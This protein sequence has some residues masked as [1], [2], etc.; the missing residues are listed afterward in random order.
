M[1]IARG[2][3]YTVT[4]ADGRTGT[5]CET[6]SAFLYIEQPGP[7]LIRDGFSVILGVRTA[8]S[9]EGRPGLPH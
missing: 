6:G 9:F 4:R 8:P 1:F 3:H 2:A 5:G 7:D